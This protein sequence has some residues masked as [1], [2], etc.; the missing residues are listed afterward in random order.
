MTDDLIEARAAVDLHG[1]T[2]LND[3]QYLGKKSVDLLQRIMN[4][5]TGIVGADIGMLQLVDLKSS[6][7]VTAA[8]PELDE[9]FVEFFESARNDADAIGAAMQSKKLVVIADV[10]KSDM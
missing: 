5:A 2:I 9:P 3:D 1:V 4:A 6:A 8:Q 10:L 7:I